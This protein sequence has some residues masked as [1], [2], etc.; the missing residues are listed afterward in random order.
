MREMAREGRVQ[1]SKRETDRGERNRGGSGEEKMIVS[2]RKERRGS[3]EER[4]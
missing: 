3:G 1:E 2:E 4:E